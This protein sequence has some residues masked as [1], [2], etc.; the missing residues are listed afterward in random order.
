MAYSKYGDV[1]DD[2]STNSIDFALMR[3]YLLG[4][5]TL[6][7]NVRSDVNGDGS[8]NSIDFAVMRQYLLGSINKYPADK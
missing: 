7:N 3:Q 2:G 8:I 1:N 6:A 4:T 5:N